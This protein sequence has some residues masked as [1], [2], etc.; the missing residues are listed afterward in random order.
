[1][2][3]NSENKQLITTRGP[4]GNVCAKWEIS[5]GLTIMLTV[6]K[7]KEAHL[8]DD[9]S[10]D[11]ATV[12]LPSHPALYSAATHR[13]YYICRSVNG[14]NGHF[15]FIK[16]LLCHIAVE[17]SCCSAYLAKLSPLILTE[18]GGCEDE[19]QLV[20]ELLLYCCC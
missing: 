13:A 17:K 19:K 20:I 14:W 5:L 9:G 3:S 18:N 2:L 8:L 11:K 6:I 1:M 16:S 7:G 10:K 15:I 4:L 12:P